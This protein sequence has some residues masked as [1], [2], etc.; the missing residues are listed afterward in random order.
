MK[1]MTGFGRG[2]AAGEKYQVS[3]DVATVNRK[4]LDIRFSPPK[5]AV[6]LDSVVRSLVPEYLA[7]GSVN[8]QLKL[9]FSSSF[10]GVQFN[11]AAITSYVQHIEKLQES[12]GIKTP[13][14]LTEIL[15]LPGA[16]DE[17]AA[18]IDIDEASA[19][20][21]EALSMALASLVDSRAKEGQHLQEDLLNR[22][23]LLV[24][25]LKDLSS[26]SVG[27]VEQFKEK[28]LGRIREAGLD[29]DFDNDRL[30][31]E[32]VLYTDRSDVTEELVRLE[33]HMKAF[34]ELLE[35]VDPV[36]REMDFLMQ[37]INREINTC[38]SKSSDS[39][40]ARLIVAMK[41]EVE[42]CREQVQNVE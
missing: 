23:Q 36:G 39:E 4:Q 16:V 35:K 11:D 19:V 33:G 13:V 38:G 20:A 28:L 18:T 17:S 2:E 27:T 9:N 8:I 15:L 31:Q 41:A 22:Q 30:Y 42:R 6:F 26:A 40:I 1:S 14:S 5:E 37:E 29:I 21:K 34:S 10:S 24:G 7:R 3:V 32:V 25:F 12:F